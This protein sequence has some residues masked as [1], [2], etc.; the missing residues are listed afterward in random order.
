M[1]RIAKG[2]ATFT[3][4]MSRMKRMDGAQFP[5]MAPVKKSSSAMAHGKMQ[6]HQQQQQQQSI[7][8]VAGGSHAEAQANGAP[9]MVRPKKKATYE[10]MFTTN[11]NDYRCNLCGV[12]KLRR[13]QIISHVH[14][15][16]SELRSYKCQSC[17]KSFKRAFTLSAHLLS[18]HD[19]DR[20]VYSCDKCSFSTTNRG[21]FISHFYRLHGDGQRFTCYHCGRHF[22]SKLKLAEH[23]A[24]H[25][26]ACFMCEICGKLYRGRHLLRAHLSTHRL[27]TRPDSFACKTC[28]KKLSCQRALDQHVKLH[29]RAFECHDCGLKFSTKRRLFQH[30]NTHTREMALTCPVCAKVFASPTIQ[31]VH[32]L[33]HVGLKPYR[34]NVCGAAFTQRTP[35]MAH[36]RKKHPGETELP[37]PVRLNDL[38]GS[39]HSGQHF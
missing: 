15:R 14:N 3:L 20:P 33:V 13:Q 29:E 5:S 17:G 26:D 11:S 10:L 25:G 22:K 23:I 31:K 18:Q 6:Q 12:S 39:R 37:P 4:T 8:V 24:I 1:V 35:M 36:W 7:A 16:H 30:R 38:L 2:S 9:E 21:S 28:H 34:C 32:S 19:P 27:A